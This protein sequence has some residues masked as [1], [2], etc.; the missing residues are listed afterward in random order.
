VSALALAAAGLALRRPWPLAWAAATLAGEALAAL[1]LADGGGW[2][3]AFALA[4]FAGVELAW[5]SCDAPPRERAARVHARTLAPLAGGAAVACG[6]VA[7][8]AGAPLAAGLAGVA[9]G[10]GGA[11]TLTVVLAALAAPP[12]GRPRGVRR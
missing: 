12:G 10:L 11:I 8:A 3:P 9:L 7:A 4:L 1:V 6:L 2:A 5:R